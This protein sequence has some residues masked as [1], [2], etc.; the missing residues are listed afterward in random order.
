M[1]LIFLPA[2]APDERR[3]GA[4]PDHVAAFPHLRVRHVRYP[5]QVWYNDTVREEAARQIREWGSGRFILVGFSK[6]ALG[7]WNLAQAFA[8]RVAATLLFD[9]PVARDDPPPWGIEGFYP[10]AASWRRDLPLRTVTAFKSAMPPTHR[11]VLV[12]GKFFH[13]EM[14]RLSDALSVEGVE[15]V[16]LPRPGMAHHWNAGWIEE[17]LAALPPA[18]LACD[19]G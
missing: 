13:D 17:A 8:D 11:L 1:Q 3:F 10:D 7:A 15:H 4:A 9:A 16:F 12:S 18:C 5:G 2:T 19:P 14:E 6:S